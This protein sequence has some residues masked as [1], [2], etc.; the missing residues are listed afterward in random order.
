[1]PVHSTS[2]SVPKQLLSGKRG[3]FGYVE[4]GGKGYLVEAVKSRHCDKP[5]HIWCVKEFEKKE[6][7]RIQQFRRNEL[8]GKKIIR[9][10]LLCFKRSLGED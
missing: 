9:N 7:K 3:N 6:E 2:I 4:K 1:M 5:L 10:A 8:A